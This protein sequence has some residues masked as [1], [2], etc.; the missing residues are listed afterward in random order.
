MATTQ[1]RGAPSPPPEGNPRR[2]ALEILVRVERDRAYANLLLDTRLSRE[3]L[4]PRDRAL[5]TELC[6][7]VLRHRGAIDFLLSQVLDRPL[8]AVDPDVRNLL[9]LGAYQLFYLTKVPTYAAVNETVRLAGKSRTAFVNAILRALER[10]GWLQE[11]E[12]PA[13]PVLRWSVQY[14]HPVWLVERWVK[15]LGGEAL[16]LMQANNQI[17]PVGIGW[18][19][20]RGRAED[21]ERVFHRAR[22]QWEASPWVPG[23]YR[24]RDGGRLLASAVRDRGLFWVMDEAAALV[25][26]LLDPQP[27]E[28]ILDVCTGGGGKAALTAILMENRGEITALD[29]SPRALRRLQDASRRLGVRIVRPMRLDAREAAARFRGWADRVLVDAPCTGLG[30]VRRRPEIRWHR[31]PADILRLADLQGTILDG[32]AGCLRSGGILV[33]AVCS[34]EPEEGE[35]VIAKFLARHPAFSREETP[36]SFFREGRASLLLGG[37]FLTWPHRHGTDGFFAARLRRQ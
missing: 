31:E 4:T 14:S 27:G 33:Y 21:L 30:T 15:R 7:G 18:N 29:V 6:Y 23:F 5:V 20:F 37:S 34:G 2:L 11:E 26:R 24:I 10:R 12:L 25:V 28:Q 19:P 32:A 8:A 36:P 1:S 17:P 22:L 13:D 3:R 35:E 16:Q 9:R